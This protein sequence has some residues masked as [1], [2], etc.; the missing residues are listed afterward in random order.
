[1]LELLLVACVGLRQCEYVASPITY[2]TEARCAHN[3]ALIAGT[4]RGRYA[5]TWSHRYRFTCRHRP[6]RLPSPHVRG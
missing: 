2:P 3:A 4:V 6:H 5:S 1:M